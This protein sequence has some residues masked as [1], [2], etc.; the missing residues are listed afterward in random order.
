M[1]FA[2]LC[3]LVRLHIWFVVHLATSIRLVLGVGKL[4]IN[5]AINPFFKLTVKRYFYISIDVTSL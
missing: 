5:H 1:A 2:A 4:T 3:A